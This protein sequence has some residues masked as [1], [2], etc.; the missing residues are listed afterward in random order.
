[1][2]VTEAQKEQMAKNLRK[3]FDL[4]NTVTKLRLAYLKQ[5]YPE[6]SEEELVHKIHLDIVRAKERQWNSE[7]T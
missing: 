1:M 3:S 6:K 7:K 5:M 2:P 4:L